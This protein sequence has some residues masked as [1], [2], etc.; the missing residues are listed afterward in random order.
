MYYLQKTIWKLDDDAQGLSYY[1]A[2]LGIF[3]IVIIYLYF[4]I[5]SVLIIYEN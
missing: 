5:K 1:I 2:I 4:L 3:A